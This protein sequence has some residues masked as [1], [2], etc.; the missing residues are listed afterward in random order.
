[1]QPPMDFPIHIDT[2]RAI[3]EKNTWGRPGGGGGGEMAGDIFFGCFRGILV[4]NGT[5]L[6]PQ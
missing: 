4:K 3:P 5:K 6:T 2:I 1:M